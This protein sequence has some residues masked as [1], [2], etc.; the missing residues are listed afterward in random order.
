MAN[1]STDEHGISDCICNGQ[2]WLV[3]YQGTKLV[4]FGKH[5]GETTTKGTIDYYD[6][7][8]EALARVAELNL[9][10]TFGFLVE[11]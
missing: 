2:H 1:I 3:A 5:A 7:E 6:T 11:E 9:E 4:F 8:E 10:D